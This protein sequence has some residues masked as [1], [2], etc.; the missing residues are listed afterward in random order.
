MP[1]RPSGRRARGRHSSLLAALC[2]ALGVAARAAR[3]EA[4]RAGARRARRR[5]PAPG[6]PCPGTGGLPRWPRVALAGGDVA[7]L[8]G[9]AAGARPRRRRRGRAGSGRARAR[10]DLGRIHEAAA[11]RARDRFRARSGRSGPHAP[12]ACVQEVA[13]PRPRSRT[14]STRCSTGRA[15]RRAA[16][17]AL[18][19]RLQSGSLRAYIVYLLVVL[20]LAARAR[21]SECSDERRRGRGRRGAAGGVALAPLIAGTRR[22]TQGA[23][24]GPARPVASSSPTAS[25]G[26]CGARARCSPEPH[27]HVYALAPARRRGDRSSRCCSCRSAARRP[28]GASGHDALVLVGVLALGRFA[29]AL[30]AWDT[31][32]RLRADG[33]EPR[34][35]DRRVRGGGAAARRAAR[36]AARGRE[37]RPGRDGDAAGGRR[38]LGR[39]RC[40]GARR[41]RSRS[42]R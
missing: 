3:P 29:L 26:G 21:G 40:T 12:A 16:R 32:E 10:V 8:A 41:S 13:L 22:K 35:D 38:H 14:C 28:A 33:R 23:P 19:R 36:D 34:P 2:V 4:G 42:S 7:L 5:R 37:H 18:A 27:T 1:L 15:A 24:A 20:V 30:A 6:S 17:R 25:C 39:A 9:I 31:G 11:A